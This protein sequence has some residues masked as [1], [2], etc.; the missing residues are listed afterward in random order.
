MVTD[1]RPVV[2]APPTCPGI[3]EVHHASGICTT[4]GCLEMKKQHL[5]LLQV[6]SQLFVPITTETGAEDA[7]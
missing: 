3:Q 6:F 4:A 7:G 1:G 2:R 5:G